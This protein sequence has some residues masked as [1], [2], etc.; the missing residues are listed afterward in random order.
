MESGVVSHYEVLDGNPSDSTAFVPA[1][2][3]HTQT[4]GRAPRIATADR[5]YFSAANI[6]KAKDGGVKPVAVPGRGRLS[7]E[8][9]KL[10]RER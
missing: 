4:F 1:I 5:G 7:Q 10:P 8:R 9:S 2:E 6:N 3:V